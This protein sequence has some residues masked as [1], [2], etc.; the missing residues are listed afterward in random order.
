[1]RKGRPG[2]ENR[3]GIAAITL[4]RIVGTPYYP[5]DLRPGDRPGTHDARLDGNIERTL[6]EVFAAERRGC[7]RQGLHLGMCRGVGKGLYKIVAPADDRTTRH[8]HGPYGHLPGIEGLARLGKG[9]AHE[10]LVGLLLSVRNR[11]GISSP[12]GIFCRC[13]RSPDSGFFIFRI[14]HSR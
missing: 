11:S 12:A 7:G 4:L 1:M 8:D 2:M 10:P 6:G 3:L 9:Q 13:G 5:P 14:R